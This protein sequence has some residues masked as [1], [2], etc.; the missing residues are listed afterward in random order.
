MIGRPQ[1]DLQKSISS[2]LQSLA[3]EEAPRTRPRIITKY[4]FMQTRNKKSHLDL[5]PEFVI[6]TGLQVSH[7]AGS[8]K[9][10]EDGR[11]GRSH[12]LFGTSRRAK[13]GFSDIAS[14]VRNAP[15]VQGV[16]LPD[17]ESDLVVHRGGRFINNEY[18]P[19]QSQ[20]PEEFVVRAELGPKS[21]VMRSGRSYQSDGAYQAND[22]TFSPLQHYEHQ[23]YQQQQGFPPVMEAD[24]DDFLIQE[25]T[26]QMCPGCP[27]FSVPV[28]IPKASEFYQEKP[29][30]KS[31]F[32]RLAD[33]VSPAIQTA[34]DFFNG[35]PEESHGVHG[36]QVDTITSRVDNIS[37]RPHNKLTT[38]LLTSLAA[39]G[40][41]LTSFFS[42]R[43]SGRKAVGELCTIH[44]IIDRWDWPTV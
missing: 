24:Q 2:V 12:S 7:D 36:G 43:L 33:M 27:T 21:V 28:P 14:A 15:V 41:G 29:E 37:E 5:P 22:Y 1:G 35:R 23:Q 9:V 10:E 40:F 32:S 11:S 39:V 42:N 16:R 13:A 8:G 38:P 30:E 34:R 17:D 20:V 25:Q 4:D 31:L 6:S 3:Q 18:V 26:Y 19:H 44:Y